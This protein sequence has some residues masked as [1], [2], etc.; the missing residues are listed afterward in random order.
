MNTFIKIY[1]ACKVC[2]LQNGRLRKQPWQEPPLG[3]LGYLILLQ[4]DTVPR[5]LPPE[6]LQEGLLIPDD[7]SS[8]ILSG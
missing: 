2:M 1:I 4:T 3:M 5:G 8:S 6:Q 7:L